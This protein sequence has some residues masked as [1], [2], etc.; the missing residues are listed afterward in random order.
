MRFIW[1]GIGGAAGSIARYAIGLGAMQQR[2]PWSTMAINLSGAFLLGLLLTWGVGKVPVAVL[3]PLAVGVLGGFTT[4]SAFCWE[5]FTLGRGGRMGWA[6]TYA[7][8][9]VIGGW[10]L[11]WAGYSAGRALH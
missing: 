4:F 6:V 8:G 5:A 10:L 7:A 11:A 1:V 9:S 3:T 2:F